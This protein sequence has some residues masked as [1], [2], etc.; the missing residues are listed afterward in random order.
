MHVHEHMFVSALS[1]GATCIGRNH[2]EA[3][4]GA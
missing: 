1:P 2:E 3:A 4:A